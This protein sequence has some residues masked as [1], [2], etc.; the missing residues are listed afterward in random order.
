MK[1]GKALSGSLSPPYCQL[2]PICLS[3]IVAPRGGNVTKAIDFFSLFDRQNRAGLDEETPSTNQDSFFSSRNQNDRATVMQGSITTYGAS[4][5][6]LGH[7]REPGGRPYLLQ[8]AST[9]GRGRQTGAV[10]RDETSAEKKCTEGR[11]AAGT[12]AAGMG[13]A[14]SGGSGTTRLFG[15]GYSGSSSSA[16]GSGPRSSSS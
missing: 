9:S 7:R 8:R 16:K 14:V 12:G 1:F 11:G 2:I 10:P 13:F 5:P 3:V 15:A 6:P 4:A